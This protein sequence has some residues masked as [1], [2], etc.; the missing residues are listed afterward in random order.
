MEEITFGTDGIRGVANKEL[1]PEVV[2]EL[3]VAVAGAFGGPVL[4]GR[5]TRISG[6]MLSAALAAGLAAGGSDVVDLGVLPTPGIAALAP[7]LGAAA[8]GVVSASH[9]PYPDNGVKFFSG[10]GRKLPTEKE[11][12]LERLLKDGVPGPNERPLGRDIGSIT[13]LTEAPERYVDLALERVRPQGGGRKCCSIV[14]TAHL[15]HRRR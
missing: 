9:N 15:T 14:R 10:A 3:G 13:P 2:F 8:A 11:R 1:T 6:G 5:D 7:E 4:V 12:E